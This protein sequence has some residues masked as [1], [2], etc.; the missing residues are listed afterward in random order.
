[1][2]RYAISPGALNGLQNEAE[3]ERLV[4]RCRELAAEGVDFLLL[5]EKR[6]SDRDLYLL[7]R[8]VLKAA[9]VGHA[10]VMVAGPV[11]VALAAAADGVHVGSNYGLVAEAKRKFIESWVSCSC[12]S[13]ADVGLAKAAGADVCLFGPVFGKTVDGVE[14]VPG[15][16]IDA[17][18]EAC[19]AA[20]T[21]L[22]VFALGGV[23]DATAGEC[24]AAGAVGV[25]GIRMFFGGQSG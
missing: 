6:L 18:R 11:Q 1:V 5:R 21:G 8:R 16:G 23:S 25:A 3:V 2:Q 24:V 15:V 20:G 19:E 17:L 13:V 12:H 4:A 9:D 10:K 14:V 22:Q 7:T